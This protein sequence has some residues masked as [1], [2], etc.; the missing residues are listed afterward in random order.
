MLLEPDWQPIMFF[1]GWLGHD[2][3]RGTV[4][5]HCKV[6]CSNDL[7][8]EIDSDACTTWQ[9]EGHD[10]LQ[11]LYDGFKSRQIAHLRQGFDPETVA[12]H[13]GDARWAQKVPGHS[14]RHSTELSAQHES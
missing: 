14:I 5:L 12:R 6:G 4:Q 8:F 2:E 9:W 7:L 11:L 3:N 10:P 1:C 13:D